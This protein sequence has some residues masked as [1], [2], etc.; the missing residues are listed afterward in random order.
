MRPFAP[1]A[2]LAALLLLPALAGAQAAPAPA[3]PGAASPVAAEPQRSS[4]LPAGGGPGRGES[5]PL[6]EDE[7]LRRALARSPALR[8]ARARAEAAGAQAASVRGHLLTAVNVSD[9]F[10]HWDSTFGIAFPIGPTPLALV[11]REQDTNTFV[12]SAG[13]PLLGLLHLGADVS[14]AGAQADAARADVRATEAA[15]RE[16]VR[17]AL[18]R[19]HEARALGEIAR[20][21]VA[22]LTD[23][24]QVTRSRVQAG[25]QTNADALR[26][27]TALAN[28]RQQVIQ[29]QAQ[30]QAEKAGLLIAVGDSPYA[31]ADFAEPPLPEPA[32]PPALE[33]AVKEARA[34]RPELEAAHRV[35]A[36]AGRRA[37][38]RALDL[39]PEVNAEAAYLHV[40]GQAFQPVDSG[41]VGVKADWP[42]WDWGAKWYA[43]GAAS[44]QADAAAAQAA[45][46]QDQVE[47]EVAARLASTLAAGNAVEVARTAIASAEEAYR[48]T[49]ALVRAGSATT[50]D[51]LDAQSAL[52]T[53]RQNLT[54]ARYAYAGA[55]IAL[56]RAMGE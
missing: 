2:A 56:G 47:T 40:S 8:A 38:A 52:T 29:A 3:R 34:K 24:L 4:P 21:S 39:L 11:A 23:Q 51:L 44:A 37:T 10:Q 18:L 30:E 26:V 35:E 7:V 19:L 50:T 32:A 36:A 27:E 1:P 25:V 17:Q 5:Q 53:A 41:F 14:A 12:A 13:Q 31:Q 28:A 6:S 55:R 45:Q 16:Q 42:I 15:V 22:Q 33:P 48:V 9:E 54:R 46:V 43:R 49:D 20:A